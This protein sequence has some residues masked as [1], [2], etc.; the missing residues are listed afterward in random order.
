MCHHDN[1]P[2]VPIWN[3]LGDSY[4]LRIFLE[5]KHNLSPIA[6]N[7]KQQQQQQSQV[8]RPHHDPSKEQDP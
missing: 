5:S 7:N 1:L 4:L 6:S 3:T 2:N 8:L